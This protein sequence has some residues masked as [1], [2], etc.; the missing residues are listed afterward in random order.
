MRCEHDLAPGETGERDLSRQLEHERAERMQ[1][2]RRLREI[3][4]SHSFG[5]SFGLMASGVI[6]DLNNLLMVIHS[7]GE[8]LLKELSPAE[9]AHEARTVILA[10]SQGASIT[11]QVLTLSRS[12]LVPARSTSLNEY[13]ALL[14][15]LLRRM[16]P[17]TV[18]LRLRP[19]PRRSVVAIAPA[20]LCQIV[21]NLVVNARDAMP[22]GGE[23]T[24]ETDSVALTTSPAPA[25]AGLRPGRYGLLEL[26]DSG[27]GMDARM[28]ERLFEPYF[29]S[30]EPGKGTGLG[31]TTVQR[32][33]REAGG[34][35]Q[36]TS[37]PGAGTSVQIYLPEL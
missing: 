18:E 3:E 32:L 15:P 9:A 20:A 29:T 5:V 27:V 14:E 37:E 33:A 31:L 36:I 12:D 21:L 26:R 25:S 28:V 24:I 16:L 35:V 30:K 4:Q 22:M 1:L 2:E 8:L 11:R 23:L 17:R 10:A 19:G 34:H 6:H 13:L 7:C